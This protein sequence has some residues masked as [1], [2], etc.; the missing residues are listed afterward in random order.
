MHR[1]LDAERMHTA[2]QTLLGEH[3]FSAFRSI[4]CQSKSPVRRM[5]AIEVKREGDFVRLD[6][7]ANAY[8]HHM[9]RNIVGTLVDA[10]ADGDPAAR[11]A[12][13]LAGRDRQHA[14]FTAP[15]EG[16]YLWRVIYPPIFGIP[17][18]TGSLLLK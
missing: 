6:F 7:T 16:L 11:M 15:A 3:D 9:V 8:L 4:E 12:A 17:S 2:A 14:G 1:P 10:Q 13:V 5:Q 18:A